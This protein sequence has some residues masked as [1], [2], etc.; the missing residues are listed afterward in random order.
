[1][2][3]IIARVRRFFNSWEFDLACMY[4]AGVFD[5]DGI[6]KARAYA[7][8][9]KRNKDIYKRHKL[10]P[11]IYNGKKIYNKDE[12][13]KIIGDAILKGNPFMAARYG[14]CELSAFTKVKNNNKGFCCPYSSALMH[15]CRDIAGFF[16]EDKNEL[17]KFADLMK[18]STKQVNLMGV[19]FNPLEEYILKTFGNDPDYCHLSALE[20]FSSKDPWSA[21]LEGKKVLVIH[22]FYKTI[23]EQYKKREKL[24]NGENIL[25]DFELIMQPAVQTIG[26]TRDERFKTWFEALNYMFDEAMKKNFDVAIIGCGAYGFPLAAKLKQAGKIVIHLGGATQLLFGIIGKR[27]ENDPEYYEFFSKYFNN[28]YWVRPD[29]SETPANK[30]RFEN[31]CYW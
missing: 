5:S 29:E 8:E 12:A 28:G 9:F 30:Q 7:K 24:F 14:S 23:P 17:I 27:W 6:N 2:F 25:P 3:G 16:P 26:G 20:P 11:E 10:P 31:G 18:K 22:P 21:K 4:A 1:M 13:N 19:W 15:L